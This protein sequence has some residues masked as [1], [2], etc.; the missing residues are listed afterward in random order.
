M[1]ETQERSGLY[2]I[3]L[4]SRYVSLKL[5][6]QH[7]LFVLVFMTFGLG[8][9]ISGS[10]MM[11]LKGIGSEFNIMAKYAY[12]NFGIMGLL[13]TKFLFTIL[14]IYIISIIEK[15]SYWMINGILIALS[16]SGLMATYANLQKIAGSSHMS[17]T[18]II[19]IYF[20]LLFALILAG[21]FLDQFYSENEHNWI[22]SK[23]VH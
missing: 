9:A 22:I 3:G 21:T 16:V 12:I 23:Y 2:F 19:S 20:I 6:L 5:N 15:K 14:P 1:P 17:P 8:D 10:F 4:F 18:D 11:D 13:A 7:I